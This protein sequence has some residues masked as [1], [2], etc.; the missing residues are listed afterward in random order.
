VK[1]GAQSLPISLGELGKSASLI[2]EF[3]GPGGMSGHRKS[4]TFGH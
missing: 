3:M 4:M 1:K 2:D